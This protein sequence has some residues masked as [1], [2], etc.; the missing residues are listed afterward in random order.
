MRGVIL[1]TVVCCAAIG[2]ALTAGQAATTPAKAEKPKTASLPPGCVEVQHVLISFDGAPRVKPP[3]RTKEQA[4]KLAQ[5][6]LERAKKGEDF[7]KLVE[8]YTSDSAP[9]IYRL[10]D[11]DPPPPTFLARAKMVKGFGDVAFALKPGEIGMASYDPQTSPYGWHII[12][13]L[14]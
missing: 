4:Q 5:E 2:L 7:L 10:C 8:K 11:Q 13:R 6:V 1:G 9:G 3:G 14:R 12:K